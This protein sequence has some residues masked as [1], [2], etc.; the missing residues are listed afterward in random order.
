MNSMSPAGSVSVNAMPVS[1]PDGFGLLMV[2]VRLTAP[3]G[4]TKSEAKALVIE[5]G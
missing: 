5:G 3:P 2:K 4:L 1:V